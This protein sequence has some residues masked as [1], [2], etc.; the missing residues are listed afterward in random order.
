MLDI[1]KNRYSQR[2]TDKEDMQGG[3]TR[4]EKIMDAL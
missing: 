4:V 3:L 1:F 2:T